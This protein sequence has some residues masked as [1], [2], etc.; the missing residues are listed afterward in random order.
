[1]TF[2]WAKNFFMHFFKCLKF[3]IVKN[4]ERFI[5]LQCHPYALAI[6]QFPLEP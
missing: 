5:D 2:S 3:K 6:A 4:L 1:M